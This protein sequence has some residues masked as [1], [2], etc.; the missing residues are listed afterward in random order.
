MSHTHMPAAS[1]LDTA[2]TALA[3]STNRRLLEELGRR[4]PL[5]AAALAQSLACS[6]RTVQRHVA[7]LRSAG[8]VQEI[9]GG[10]DDS[11]VA[12]CHEV[13]ARVQAWGAAF[14]SVQPHPQ[15]LQPD[16]SLNAE[17][18][19]LES[20]ADMWARE[21]QLDRDIYLIGQRLLRLGEHVHTAL[22]EAAG[23]EG[24]L[25]TEL[26]LLDALMVAG[27]PH[28][29]TPT[30]LQSSLMLTKGGVTKCISRLEDA[31][32]VRRLPDPSDGRGVL[33]QMTSRARSLLKRIVETGHV[34]TDWVASS[35]MSVRERAQL[36]A[37]LRDMLA[38]ADAEQARRRDPGKSP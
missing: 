35:Q 3:D 28:A 20:R 27:P 24:L 31:G 16:A 14:G 32:L 4:G 26:L 13:F 34:G 9:F 5:T 30:Q 23:S 37:L 11:P 15:G 10:A 1:T 33:V 2:F 22:K 8:L 25:G 6:V 38:L 36:S 12:L 19:A 21:W 18:D 7:V 17:P 29:V